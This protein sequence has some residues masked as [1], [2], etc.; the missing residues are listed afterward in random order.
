MKNKSLV[1]EP[2]P[3][4]TVNKWKFIVW[5]F[6]ITIVML[7]ASQTSAYL[8][9]RAE[10]NWTEFQ[11]PMIFWYST[12]VLLLSSVF[13]H[14]AVRSTKKDNFAA[15]KINISAAF[16]LGM[17]FLVMQYI[18]W[19][20]LQAQG[21]YLKGN[22]AGSFYYILTG[23]HGFHL[24]TG[25]VVMLFAFWASMKMTIHSKNLIRIQVCATYWH[26]L[27]LLWLYLF[28]F[29]LFFR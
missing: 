3:I 23:L 2:K 11:I 22:P 6:I 13:M 5:L 21:I 10:G 27:D 20:E 15:L 28:V 12:G 1:Q 26:F 7:F 18:G 9:R 17:I 24:I 19:Q 16:A 29:L 8:V 25:L 4:L 14:F